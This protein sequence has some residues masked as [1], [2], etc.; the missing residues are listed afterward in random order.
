MRKDTLLSSEEHKN[1]QLLIPH[2]SKQ[3]IVWGPSFS[4]KVKRK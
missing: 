2:L 3:E 1:M 4:R